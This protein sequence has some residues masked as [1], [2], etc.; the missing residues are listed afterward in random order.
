MV[1]L[2]K[3]YSLIINSNMNEKQYEQMFKSMKKS[4]K[5]IEMMYPSIDIEILDLDNIK[6]K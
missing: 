1:N 6:E 4:F 5:L 2:I 3:E